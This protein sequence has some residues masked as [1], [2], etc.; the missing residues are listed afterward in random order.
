[1]INYTPVIQP[2]DVIA[3]GDIHGRFDLLDAFCDHVAD[4]GATVVFLGD[5]I[6]RGGQDLEVLD[7]IHYMMMSPESW[8]LES[9]VALMGNHEWMFIDAAT[10]PASS[11]TLWLQNGGNFEAYADM[12]RHLPWIQRL[13]V[14][15]IIGD[16]LFIHAGFYPGKD[17][18]ETIKLGRTENLLWMRQPFLTYG[19]EFEKWNPNLKRVVF[20]HTPESAMPYFIP[21]GGIC[22]DTGAFQTGVLTTYNA[23][24]NTFW[25]H[26]DECL[27]DF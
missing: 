9:V 23:T 22:I 14:F 7:R 3:V 4:S 21:G 12:L 2:G 1:M 26:E 11:L 19:P 18:A 17:P 10:G 20:G 6:D 24:Q 13:P 16:T 27:T 8:G 5:L 15:L 25:S